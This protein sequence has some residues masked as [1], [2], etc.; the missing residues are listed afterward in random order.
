MAQR[1]N[2]TS[3]ERCDQVYEFFMDYYRRNDMSPTFTEMSNG[4]G[5]GR[6]NLHKYMG[7]LIKERRIIQKNTG[8]RGLLPAQPSQWSYPLHWAGHIAANSLN[9]LVVPD[10][11]DS[12]TT[13]EVPKYLLPPQAN[14]KDLYV[15]QVKG[16]SMSAANILD[17]DYVVMQSGN[18]FRDEEVLAIFIK[19]ENAV[20]LKVLTQTERGNARLEPRSHKHQPRIENM[21]NIEV[22]GRVVAIMRKCYKEL[23]M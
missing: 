17:G 4:T 19:D 22:Q 11:Q 13:I 21:E 3:T 16:D 8:P 20:T 14:V 1:K 6:G 2:K 7:Q 5:I 9:P 18:N 15:L 12:E 23:V 10:L